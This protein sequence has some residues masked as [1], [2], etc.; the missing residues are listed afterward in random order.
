M[1]GLR[2]TFSSREPAYGGG[3]TQAATAGPWSIT[4]LDSHRLFNTQHYLC[5]S[6]LVFPIIGML[7]L[8][9]L[10]VWILEQHEQN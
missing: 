8:F 1:R 7:V 2:G 6:A 4:T 5:C 3:D 9:D 10:F